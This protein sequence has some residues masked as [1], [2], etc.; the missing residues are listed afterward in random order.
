MLDGC[1][2]ETCRVHR[3]VA[4]G[5]A[6]HIEQEDWRCIHKAENRKCGV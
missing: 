5:N 6:W 1:A 2:S 3:Q 4:R